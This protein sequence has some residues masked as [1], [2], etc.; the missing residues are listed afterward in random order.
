MF[1][2]VGDPYIRFNLPE[3]PLFGW[4]W[5]GLLLVG[6]MMLIWRWRALQADWQRAGVLLLLLAP[7]IML[8]PTAVAVNEIVPSNLRAI[9]LIPFIFY[10]PGVGLMVFVN[11]LGN[12]FKRIELTS[13]V[14]I[15]GV[16][17]LMVG[18]LLTERLYFRV[19][20]QD[21]AVFYETDGDLTAVADFL[22]Q[23]DTEGKNI[24]VSALH[25]QHPT[26]AYLSEKYE[27]VKWLP[28]S[29]AVVFPA[30][31]EAIYIFPHN[32]PPPRWAIDYFAGAELLF[33]TLAPD[34]SQAFVAYEMGG[35]PNTI[36]PAQSVSVNFGNA[37]TLLGY[38]V[39]QATAGETLPLILYWQVNF[40][41]TADF[42]PFIHFEDNWGHRWSQEETFAYPS[43]QWSRGETIVQRVEIEVPAGSPLGSHY[44]M[45]VGLFSGSSGERLPR[46]D[47]N[48][49]YAGDTYLIENI[50]VQPGE[51]PRNLPQPPI[52]LN[53]TIRPQL[54]L[55]GVMREAFEAATGE[56][57][58]L[59]LW[60]HATESVPQTSIRLEL[61]GSNNVGRILAN[62]QPVHNTYSFTSW[63]PPQFL[64]DWQTVR[65]PNNIPAG[66]YRLLARFLDGADA[67]LA[68]ADLGPLR[69]TVTE[70]SF[71][72]PDVA[73][74]YP[75]TFGNEIRLLG[76]NLI[77]LDKP[78][79]YQ[80]DLIWQAQTEP[81]ND[82]TVF[83]HLLQAGGSCNPCLWQQD[84]M[85]QQNQYPT[86]RWLADEVVTDS[87]QITLP[88]ET[89]AGSYQLE[90]GLYIAE[91]GQR[92]QVV[93]PN[94]SEGDAVFLESITVP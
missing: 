9:G 66:E 91:T 32:S 16:L 83:V 59:A 89:P 3:R 81:G 31:E 1:F 34:G 54:E 69:V 58:D 7:F 15:V 38:D 33:S 84:V 42:T 79:Q 55:L 78:E 76:Y 60:W 6:W 88:P 25:Y 48:G 22:D 74:P 68:T 57:V 5:G 13:A 37:I 19:W 49:R 18:G 26:L 87:Y 73:R 14:L 2:L 92:L 86:S 11:D 64:I 40:D 63:H 24:Y 93:Q 17:A 53:Q 41:Q 28:E 85:P 10:L 82:Y 39:S 61:M 35:T 90:I 80:L 67:T 94:G 62:T 75:A 70:R 71:T 29:Q 36:T 43:A 8:L 77:P 20:G 47:E 27:Q 21:T 30:R 45:R 44:Q 23:L 46:L 51:M 4:F 65:V 72:V 50:S 52:V 12:Q 56:S